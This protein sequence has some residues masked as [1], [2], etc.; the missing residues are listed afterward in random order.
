M[1]KLVRT[2]VTAVAVYAA[3]SATAQYQWAVKSSGTGLAMGLGG[4]TDAS[5]NIYIGG[6]YSN[7]TCIIGS[8]TLPSPTN[9]DA[10]FAKYNSSGTPLWAI[11][12]AG[13]GD[14]DVKKVVS[15][16]SNTY[17]TGIFSGTITLYST[18]SATTALV[19]NGSTDCYVAKYNASGVL[20]WVIK[21]G[22]TGGDAPR[23][24]AISTTQQKIYL[25]GTLGGAFFAVSYGYTSL[26]STPAWTYSSSAGSLVNAGVAAD[27]TGNCYLLGSYSSA[28]STITLPSGTYTGDNGS[29]L[30]KLNPNGSTAWVQNIGSSSGGQEV[31]RN[32]DLDA[33]GNV[34]IVGQYMFT[35]NIS[36]IS[37]TNANTTQWDVFVAKYNSS[38]TV[39]WARKLS[40]SGNQVINALSV[41]PLGEAY[42]YFLNFENST[43]NIGCQTHSSIN[44]GT[45]NKMVIVKYSPDGVVKGS[46]SPS[47]DDTNGSG[48][49][50]V[51]MGSSGTIIT[52]GKIYGTGV[53]GGTTLSM[54]GN[55]FVA[56]AIIYDET[57][58]VASTDVHICGIGATANLSATGPL[59]STIKWYYPSTTLLTTGTTYVTPPASVLSSTVYYVSSTVAGCE[60]G[61]IPVTVTAHA[62]NQINVTPTNTTICNGSC[63]TVTF[64]NA[65][66]A[67]LM[68]GSV[69]KTSPFVICPTATTNYTLT[70][71]AS[72]YCEIP[73]TIT[74]NVT[75]TDPFA[76]TFSDR[77][78]VP[79]GTGCLPAITEQ[80]KPGSTSP[81]ITTPMP[82]IT[83]TLVNEFRCKIGNTLGW[84]GAGAAGVN[85]LT[86][87]GS[88]TVDVYEVEVPSG[89]RKVVG[90][91]VAPSIFIKSGVSDGTDDMRFNDGGLGA[92]F[93]NSDSVFFCDGT[94][95]IGGN[96]GSG[97]YFRDYYRYCYDQFLATGTTTAFDNF[98]SRVF[99][100]DM[101]QISTSGGCTISKKTYFRIA[102]DTDLSK[103]NGSAARVAML[104]DEGT[105]SEEEY[106]SLS[107]FPNP[108]SGLL[109]IPLNADDKNVQVIITDNLGKQV[110]KT[111]NLESNHGEL[112]IE[113][114]PSG[115]YFYNVIKNNTSYKGKIV[116]H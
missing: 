33:S 35:A 63:V 42:V 110:I 82:A 76:G 87:V 30:I 114:L 71:T 74:V 81:V 34:Y 101:I 91:Q 83:S 12:I 86:F 85:K 104:E 38:G 89:T 39:Q 102:Y 1:K 27:A 54:T 65:T 116:K 60:S 24:L 22:G 55:M 14:E 53:F 62:N 58:T 11:R 44:G 84:M 10:F 9:G 48:A 31:A 96:N 43:M 68:P 8:T 115:I 15:D 73:G 64:N 19:S 49:N 46:L 108:T 109:N 78:I 77:I 18:T 13:A 17:I 95:D 103:N 107:V 52:T 67:I 112:N 47:T 97:D 106:L 105:K 90:S 20:Q 79:S 4:T 59:G 5:G 57:P 32:I 113:T 16:G 37:L 88:Y 40:S 25:T 21:Y 7:G 69:T 29:L 70:N 23:D 50:A 45:D 94:A 61:K 28:T 56:K 75:V 99:C 66:T 72:G 100:I 51:F 36:G 41:S 93:D 6:G 98:S 26:P 92:G 3:T 2:L 111:D 80:S